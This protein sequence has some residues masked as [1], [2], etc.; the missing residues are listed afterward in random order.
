MPKGQFANDWVHEIVMSY[1]PKLFRCRITV[2][3]FLLNW[4]MLNLQ[5]R[6]SGSCHNVYELYKISYEFRIISKECWAIFSHQSNIMSLWDCRIATW[7]FRINCIKIVIFEIWYYYIQRVNKLTFKGK[8]S[9][10][11]KRLK[12]NKKRSISHTP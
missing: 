4:L 2:L 8:I 7:T 12:W 11:R 10:S 1:I 5:T 9:P 3:P 6:C